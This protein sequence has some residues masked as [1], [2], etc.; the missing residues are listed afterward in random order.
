MLSTIFSTDGH[1]LVYITI[2]DQKPCVVVDSR[3]GPGYDEIANLM[4]SVDGKHVVYEGAAGEKRH[5]VMDGLTRRA[6]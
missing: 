4:F 6:V 2:R 5:V 1:H 3:K